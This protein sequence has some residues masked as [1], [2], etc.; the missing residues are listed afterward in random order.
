MYLGLPFVFLALQRWPKYR[1]YYA[2]SGLAI[3]ALA[4][5]ISSFSTRVWQLILTQGVLY[6]LGGM[7]LYAPTITF[8]DEWFVRRKGFAYGIMWVR[9][10]ALFPGSVMCDIDL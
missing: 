3:T 10:I 2:P 4:L 7:L 6:A 5:I 1:L 9:N 8:L